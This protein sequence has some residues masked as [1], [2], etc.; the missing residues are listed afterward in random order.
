MKEQPDIAARLRACTQHNRPV[1]ASD[2]KEAA[3]AIDALRRDAESSRRAFGDSLLVGLV[4]RLVHR[5]CDA[6]GRPPP[7]NAFDRD[8]LRGLVDE[9]AALRRERDDLI[10]GDLPEEDEDDAV[11]PRAMTTAERLDEA[12]RRIAL[13][14]SSVRLTEH[15]LCAAASTMDDAY[16]HNPTPASIAGRLR[17]ALRSEDV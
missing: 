10:P 6:L 11:R 9:V 1:L 4:H 2:L 16:A 7:P 5:L 13:L 15:R 8:G 3:D 14:E 17:V 12:D